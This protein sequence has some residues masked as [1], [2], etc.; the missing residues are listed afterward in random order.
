MHQHH[1]ALPAY[2]RFLAVC[3]SMLLVLGGLVIW[4]WNGPG[5]ALVASAPPFVI[6]RQADGS[7]PAI[8]SDA[9][10][11][12]WSLD[13]SKRESKTTYN[14]T[15]LS[16]NAIGARIAS[17]SIAVINLSTDPLADLIAR[18]VIEGLQADT[19]LQCISY[20]PAN[21]SNLPGELAP[22]LVMTIAVGDHKEHGGIGNGTADTQ[23][24]VTLGDQVARGRSFTMRPN[25][26]PHHVNFQMTTTAD[27]TIE[28]DG[29]VTPNAR[30]MATAKELSKG[31][32]DRTRESIDNLRSKHGIFPELPATFYPEYV[33]LDESQ[34]Q[35]HM[36]FDAD[37]PCEEL[38]SWRD[39]LVHNT[40]WWHGQVAGTQ[41]EAITRISKRL[42]TAGFAP[43]E[44]NNKHDHSFRKGSLEV[45]LMPEEI[46]RSTARIL[47]AKEAPVTAPTTKLHVRYTHHVAEGVR[48]AALDSVITDG[49]SAE[50]LLLCAPAWDN[51]QRKRGTALIESHDLHDPDQLLQRACMR[52]DAGDDKGA[53]EDLA[54]GAIYSKASF[55]DGDTLKRVQKKAKELELSLEDKLTDREWLAALGL[56]ELVADAEP[57]AFDV[58]PE[59]PLRAIVFD[60]S[61][62]TTVVVG[63]KR[64]KNGL[65]G[66]A[67]RVNGTV[68]HQSWGM[69]KGTSYQEI[70][71][72]DGII[73]FLDDPSDGACRV[74]VQMNN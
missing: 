56:Q 42:Q 64:G 63:L 5:S 21:A 46:R 31:I 50:L 69:G 44:P 12:A 19:E 73:K 9:P 41:E 27:T 66:G 71:G 52:S 70:A 10:D 35:A 53:A 49:S 16:S 15:Q 34:F 25:Q 58:T 48:R 45:E 28:Q 74:T 62:T 23:V 60:E 1:P 68:D 37:E 32:V 24:T 18:G 51:A 29:I 65:W 39:Q 11:F 55:R 2:R 30:L 40:S 14:T 61:T 43:A 67:V 38:G 57:L 26:A 4:F 3:I 20:T 33:P 47:A 7:W 22:D 72:K 36:V 17:R 6:E 8:P 59:S 13:V 54:R